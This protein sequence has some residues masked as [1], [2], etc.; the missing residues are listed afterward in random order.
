M[1]AASNFKPEFLNRLDE[2]VIFDPTIEDLGKIVD[3]QLGKIAQRLKSRRIKIE[4]E[5]NVRQYLAE[6]GYDRLRSK[7]FK[8]INSKRNR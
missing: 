2:E 6:H 8:T 1:Q 5:G 7:T 3:L 4:V